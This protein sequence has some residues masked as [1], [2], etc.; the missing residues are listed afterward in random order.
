MT[1][2][3]YMM[4]WRNKWITARADSID[5]FITT[6]D[7]L[8]AHFRKLKE[9]GITLYEDGGVGDDYATFITDDME[10]AVR[11]GFVVYKDEELKEGYLLTLQGEE[12]RISDSLLEKYGK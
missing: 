2:P 9:W 3:I 5:D 11:A 6:Y 4:N 8:A 12:V 1:K 7:S 10:T